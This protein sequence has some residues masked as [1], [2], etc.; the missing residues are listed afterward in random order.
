MRAHGCN[1]HAPRISTPAKV[2]GAAIMQAQENAEN[3]QA[4]I[5]R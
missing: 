3:K 2:N 1:L 4:R 5:A